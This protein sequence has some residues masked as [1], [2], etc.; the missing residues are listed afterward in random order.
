MGGERDEEIGITGDRERRGEERM[1][2]DKKGETMRTCGA[3]DDGQRHKR[4]N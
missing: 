3:E 2:G 4:P 1:V